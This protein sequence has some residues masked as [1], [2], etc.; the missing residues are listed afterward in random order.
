MK[1]WLLKLMF[2]FN[3]VLTR[4]DLHA[5]KKFVIQFHTTRILIKQFDMSTKKMTIIHFS[6]I[7]KTQLNIF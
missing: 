3:L 7:F 6:Y 1:L 2:S 4:V 5:P